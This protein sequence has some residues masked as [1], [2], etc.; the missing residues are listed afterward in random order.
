[1]LPESGVNHWIDLREAVW[2]FQ[3]RL[4]EKPRYIEVYVQG[5][6]LDRV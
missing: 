5:V 1:M 3:L 2:I 4:V 6:E